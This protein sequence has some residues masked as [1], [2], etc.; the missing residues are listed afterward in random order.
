[1]KFSPWNRFG[2]PVMTEKQNNCQNSNQQK[3]HH[4]IIHIFPVIMVS[5]QSS[6]NHRKLTSSKYQR[7]KIGIELTSDIL[8]AEDEFDTADYPKHQKTFQ[9]T[10]NKTGSNKQIDIGLSCTEPTEKKLKGKVDQQQRFTG[11]CVQY[12]GNNE[13]RY[14]HTSR[15]SIIT[16]SN[17]F[18]IHS[19]GI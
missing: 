8:W 6:N 17:I 7:I 16:N 11:E 9:K 13:I 15:S 5:Q 1:M 10:N 18:G 2:R 12:L 4:E 3:Q 19:Q 14:S